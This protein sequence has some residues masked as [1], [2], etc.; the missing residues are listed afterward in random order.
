VTDFCTKYILLRFCKK[1]KQIYGAVFVDVSGYKI[2][3]VSSINLRL[4]KYYL[5]NYL[6]GVLKEPV[7][8]G[9]G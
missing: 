5:D 7:E 6:V 4:A 9:Q 2:T 8:I 1:R 3:Y